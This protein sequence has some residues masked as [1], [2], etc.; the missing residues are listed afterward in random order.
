M[1]R[2]ITLFIFFS[3]IL[4]FSV[5]PANATNLSVA[6]KPA[7]TMATS[8]D[9]GNPYLQYLDEDTRKQYD[10]MQGEIQRVE[11]QQLHREEYDRRWNILVIATSVLAIIPMLR[12]F[13]VYASDEECRKS[14]KAMLYA[15]AVTFLGALALIIL[16]VGQLY[17]LFKLENKQQQLVF[18]ALILI[19]AIALWIYVK[20]SKRKK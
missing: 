5:L 10:K 16:N 11:E 19:L 17:F 15:A 20:R 3:I 8:D 1:A 12:L 7:D 13:W 6:T 18:S 2:K 9:Q 14:G 4:G